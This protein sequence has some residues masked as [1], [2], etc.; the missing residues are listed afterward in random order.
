MLT[1][2]LSFVQTDRLAGISYLLERNPSVLNEKGPGDD[3]ALLFAS[4]CGHAETA[5]R[6]RYWPK[7]HRGSHAAS[8]P[9]LF[10]DVKIPE[11]A[12]AL[13]EHGADLE[14]R[15]TGSHLYQLSADSVYGNT[16]G[17]PLAWAVAAN[18]IA[19]VKALLDLGADP[20]DHAA[21]MV[22][23]DDNYNTMTHTSPVLYAITTHRWQLLEIMLP[24]THDYSSQLNSNDRV[25]GAEG[26]ADNLTLLDYCV[27]SSFDGAR[28]LGRLLTHGKDHEKAFRKT[29]E[30]L[31]NRG[32]DPFASWGP[33]DSV[34]ATAV[35]WGHTETVRY[36]L[37]W[38]EGRLQPP[39]SA[40]IK[41]LA[42]A[43]A[44]S[45]KLTF[46]ALIEQSPSEAIPFSE[47]T[48]YF[49]TVIPLINDVGFL[50]PLVHRLDPEFDFTPYLRL[51]LERRNFEAFRWLYSSG[52]CSISGYTL[53][54]NRFGTSIL[55]QLLVHSKQCTFRSMAIRALL[56]L[57]NLPDDVFFHFAELSGSVLSA[58]HLAAY[59]TEY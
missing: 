47:W 5:Q 35:Q 40:W 24:Q 58:L 38:A 32:A 34:L 21:S 39:P 55:G 23:V 3:T 29:F 52:R 56:G 42:T 11:F 12:K 31:I 59:N 8:L 50:Q 22:Q 10:P 15:S 48:R 6:C 46:D 49:A 20:F 13:V 45:N 43:A 9:Q 26:V 27:Q 14:A 44:T 18:N 17:T 19:A 36:L 28:G 51:A 54:K 4:R 37:S 33:H 53:D 30:L 41:C 16:N 7:E 2:L 1:L 25:V 57:P